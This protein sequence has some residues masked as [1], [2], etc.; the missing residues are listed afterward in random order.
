MELKLLVTLQRIKMLTQKRI[1]E[2][3]AAKADSM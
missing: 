1:E 2:L 3:K